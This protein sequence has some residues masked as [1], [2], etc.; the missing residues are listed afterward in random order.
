MA[1]DPLASILLKAG[2]ID[3]VDLQK[4]EAEQARWGGPLGRYL[5][6]MGL[7]HEETLIRA[8]STQYKMP[9]VA[10]DPPKM[11][12]STAHLIPK[13][14]CERHRLICFHADRDR[15][16]LDIAIAD[17]SNLDGIDEVRVVT[18]CNIHSHIAGPVMIDK[19][20]T[21]VFYRDVTLGSEIDLGPDVEVEVSCEAEPRAHDRASETISR[22]SQP[23]I[24]LPPDEEE[25]EEEKISSKLASGAGVGPLLLTK[26]V[27]RKPGDGFHI[28]M[29]LSEVDIDVR[30][31][32]KDVRRLEERVGVM[33]EML[34][35]D[36]GI[37]QLVLHTLVTKGILTRE[38]LQRLTGR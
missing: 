35:R 29:D 19:A 6:D 16:F 2:L 32:A 15:K 34:V 4:A 22:P 25:V 11:D 26:T 5:V 33:E 10:L 38:E 27:E 28:T 24:Q 14:L 3:Q 8:L 20:I 13:E 17:P 18:K 9:A 21:H 12:I 37:L 1:R 7:I 36:R 31:L 30:S 23:A